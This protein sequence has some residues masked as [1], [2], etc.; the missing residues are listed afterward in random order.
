VERTDDDASDVNGRAMSVTFLLTRAAPD[1]E[2]GQPID[3][4]ESGWPPLD[5]AAVER[6]LGERPEVRG[7]GP[8][9]AIRRVGEAIVSLFLSRAG[10]ELRSLSATVRGGGDADVERVERE[11][12]ALATALGAGVYLE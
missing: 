5:G 9:E 2:I 8:N 11:M 4:D 10:G 12:H 3:E 1:P 6:W 7:D